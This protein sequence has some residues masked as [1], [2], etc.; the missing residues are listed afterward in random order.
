MFE[1]VVRDA[2]NTILSQFAG[3]MMYVLSDEHE[4]ALSFIDTGVLAAAQYVEFL[5]R[6]LGEFYAAV[7][8]R[9]KSIEWWNN[10]VKLGFCNYHYLKTHCTFLNNIRQERGFFDLLETV[11]TKWENFKV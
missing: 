11:K 2:P 8:E 5:S 7:N 1:L 6:L 10:A 4:K 9:E 3:A